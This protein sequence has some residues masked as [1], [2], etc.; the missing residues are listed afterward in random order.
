MTIT[1]QSAGYHGA[2]VATRT[3]SPMPPTFMPTQLSVLTAG[4]SAVIAQQPAPHAISNSQP[5]PFAPS[6]VRLAN[7]MG[8]CW[9]HGYTY[10]PNQTSCTC[11]KHADGHQ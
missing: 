8:W 4:I 3:H 2:H 1:T 6:L 11:C 9:M 7:I 5:A 10:N